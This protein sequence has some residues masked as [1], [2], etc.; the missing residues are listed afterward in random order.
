VFR[1]EARRLGAGPHP[2]EETLDTEAALALGDLG[3]WRTGPADVCGVPWRP[4]DAAAVEGAA[5]ALLEWTDRGRAAVGRAGWLD[6]ERC[7]A[8]AADLRG[9]PA[10]VASVLQGVED[11]CARERRVE[12]LRRAL[13][14][15]LALR[16]HEKARGAFPG[17]LEML[18]TGDGYGAGTDPLSAQPFRYER[19][20]DG[21]ARLWSAGPDGKDDGGRPVTVD[22]FDD[23]G[24]DWVFRL[25]P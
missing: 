2:L 16:A 8:F 13:R 14:L 21:S 1:S 3:N 11:L 15:V 4:S 24:G 7:A 9:A 5:R 17:S 25:R 20:P 19:L 22:F 12:T 6:R 10:P 18:R 23:A